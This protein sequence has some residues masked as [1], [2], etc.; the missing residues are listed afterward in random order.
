MRRGKKQ[1]SSL[2]RGSARVRNARMDFPSEPPRG[3]P[4]KVPCAWHLR[5][6][7]AGVGRSWDRPGIAELL[8]NQGWASWAGFRQ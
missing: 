3:G 5:L 2:S 6:V 8:T 4:P 1:D 7:G